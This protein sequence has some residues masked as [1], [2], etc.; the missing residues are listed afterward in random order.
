MSALEGVLLPGSSGAV[1]AVVTLVALG[2][3]AGLGRVTVVAR[4]RAAEACRRAEEAARYVHVVSDELERAAGLRRTVRRE[5]RRTR[6]AHRDMRGAQRV[7]AMARSLAGCRDAGELARRAALA[8]TGMRE[9]EGAAV[10]TCDPDGGGP[11]VRATAGHGV[12]DPVTG[13]DG[14]ADTRG[15]SGRRMRLDDEAGRQVGWLWLVLARPG[16]L[17]TGVASYVAL[18]GALLGACD[19]QR[20]T[21]RSPASTGDAGTVTCATGAV[22]AI[23]TRG[24]GEPDTPRGERQL[25]S[26]AS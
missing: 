16:R 9:I 14:R 4:R 12:V 18:T 20:V 1:L 10:A 17:P 24:D 23:R 19:G 5:R 11:V 26:V 6:R 21:R 25:E 3:A 2:L 22:D 13:P 8:L 15:Q 7:L